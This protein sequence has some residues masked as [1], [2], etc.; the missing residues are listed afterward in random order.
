MDQEKD[1]YS[2]AL[3]ELGTGNYSDDEMQRIVNLMVY[4]MGKGH[5][6]FLKK[7]DIRLDTTRLKKVSPFLIRIL[8][9]VFKIIETNGG[10]K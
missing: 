9:K 7:Y 8:K 4:G 3:Y 1:F 2:K 10:E 6:E 5:S